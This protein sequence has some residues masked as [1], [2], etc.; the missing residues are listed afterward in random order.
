VALLSKDI[1]FIKTENTNWTSS[2]GSVFTRWWYWALW[3]VPVFV[4]C[5]TWV[6]QRRENALRSD[7]VKFKYQR[8]SPM[9]KRRL[10]EAEKL[11][12]QNQSEDFYTELSKTLSGLIADKLNIPQAGLLSD[13]VGN[14]LKEKRVEDG[15]VREYLECLHWCDQ[16]RFS[17]DRVLQEKIEDVY[18]RVR[19][20][21]FSLDK[22][23]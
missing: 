3:V 11:M 16:A 10:R 8:A 17:P 13:V 7:I 18:R 21:I 4:T 15:L 5:G 20:C 9:A 23:I 14:I 6:Y 1:R 2:D 12:A 19:D 22:A